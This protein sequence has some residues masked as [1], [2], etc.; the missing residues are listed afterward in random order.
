MASKARPGRIIGGR[1]RL[2]EELAAGGFGRVWKAHDE[3]LHV[4]VAVK[5]VWL[6]P[7][8]SEAEHRERL[9]RAAREARNAA[10][11]RDH[12]HI[13]AVHDLVVEDDVPWMVMRLVDGRSLEQ[14]LR[15]D[16]PLPARRVALVARALLDA[17]GA[18]HDAG[19]THR[20]V[21]PANVMLT[22]DGQV[23]LTD[24]G[25]SVHQTD[26][27]L[28]ATGGIIGSAEYMAPERLN[29]SDDEAAGDLFSLGVT[30]YQA[31]E[32]VSPFR[33]NTPTATLGAVVLHEAPPPQRA[34]A[35]APLITAL[36]AKDPRDR[37]T[38][39]SA[40]AALHNTPTETSPPPKAPKAPKP[41]KPPKPREPHPLAQST[42][43][44]ANDA[45]VLLR[46]LVDGV[47]LGRVAGSETSAFKVAPGLHSILVRADGYS[48]LAWPMQVK[49][50]STVNLVARTRGDD[51]LLGTADGKVPQGADLPV[52]PATPVGRNGFAPWFS[53]LGG[54][55]VILIC[56]WMAFAAYESF[57]EAGRE[58]ANPIGAALVSAVPA[59]GIWGGVNAM[60]GQ[61]VSR[62]ATLWLAWIISFGVF[63]VLMGNYV[64]HLP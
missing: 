11:L 28:T 4:D 61:T 58:A 39:K 53:L 56:G 22:A 43:T 15:T 31:V 63:A 1:Y 20:D 19:I 12:A 45:S 46:V 42:I 10:K 41:A 9:L 48:S 32:G 25:I 49:P 36:L 37:P 55:L 59:S 27:A 64:S 38:A 33:R 18:A 5:E 14:H 2:I 16:G 8:A 52:E 7:A 17:L 62:R 54:A 24:F 23:L 57:A 47:V 50:G 34:G 40:L 60:A 3:T 30:L 13:V 29:G 21:K 6:P 44:V 51:V 26:T 35:L